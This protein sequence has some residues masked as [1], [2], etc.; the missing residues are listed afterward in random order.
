MV[1]MGPIDQEGNISLAIRVYPSMGR[2]EAE[3]QCTIDWRADLM[4]MKDLVSALDIFQ[5][6]KRSLRR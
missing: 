1:I 5:G 4:Y 6:I 2:S 3:H